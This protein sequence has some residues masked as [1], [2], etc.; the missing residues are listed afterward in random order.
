MGKKINI[1][2]GY[3]QLGI[4]SAIL[5]LIHCAL[6]PV[7]LA[8]NTL[9][10][11]VFSDNDN[12]DYIFLILSCLAVFFAARHARKKYLSV[13]LVVVF[14]LF[15]VSVLLSENEVFEYV[16]WGSSA[17]LAMLH[18]LNMRHQKKA[19]KNGNAR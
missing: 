18:L 4:V 6:L 10:F 3:D 16:S 19:I 12:L 9:F 14:L 5:C 11:K 17:L 1:V 13:L 7:F 2:R 15:L 8:G